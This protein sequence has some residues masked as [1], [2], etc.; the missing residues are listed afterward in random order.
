M[1]TAGI[2]SILVPLATASSIRRSTPGPA[3]KMYSDLAT[4]IPMLVPE[5]VA[6]MIGVPVPSIR[7]CACRAGGD[8]TGDAWA[9]S[10]GAE[11]NDTIRAGALTVSARHSGERAND[12]QLMLVS[13]VEVGGGRQ[14][15][16]RTRLDGKRSIPLVLR[17]QRG[18]S[19]ILLPF[20]SQTPVRGIVS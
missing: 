8:G 3:S 11:V 20:Q 16:S 19:H 5:C 9:N 2:V 17:C 1:N 7:I 10:G 13:L 15:L 12:E 18:R 14:T 4:R 6:S